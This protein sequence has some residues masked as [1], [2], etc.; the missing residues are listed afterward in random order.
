MIIKTLEESIANYSSTSKKTPQNGSFSF[1]G[2]LNEITSKST[3]ENTDK[4]ETIKN[5]NP[6]IDN[7]PEKNKG[8]VLKAIKDL[9]GIFDIDILGDPDQF[10]NK[11]DYTINLPRIISKFG[12]NVSPGEL[13]DLGKAINTLMD[14][15][16]IR[17]ED[18]FAALKWIATRKEAFRIKIQS[19]E[20][21]KALSDSILTPNRNVDNKEKLII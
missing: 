2:I 17:K 10:I 21:I 18:Y 13:E 15:G 8:E 11:K 4:K 20:G 6:L 1:S 3:T 12:Q 9:N 19:E 16:L 5:G 7:L 14:N